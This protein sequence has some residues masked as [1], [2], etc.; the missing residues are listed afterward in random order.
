LKL[1]CHLFGL[2]HEIYGEDLEV[3]FVAKLRD[4][5]KFAGLEELR[6]QI[7]LDAAEAR[8]ILEG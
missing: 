6:R 4:E 7:A 8:R 2:D 3:E 1:E 5:R